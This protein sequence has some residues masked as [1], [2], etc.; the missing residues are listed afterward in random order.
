MA[1]T[2][3][4]NASPVMDFWPQRK[5]D[6]FIKYTLVL[7]LPGIA[8]FFFL[9]NGTVPCFG[10]RTRILLIA[11]W[12]FGCCWAVFTLRQAL[13]PCPMLCRGHGEHGTR[14]SRCTISWEEAWPGQLIWT[15]QRIFHNKECHVHYIN[16]GELA[17]KGPL[18]LGDG[19]SLS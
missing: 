2:L 6:T 1:E 9:V 5:F 15:G 14:A 17:M 10:C 18:L 12:C 7:V 4:A 3:T 16:Y 8:S 11:Q 13:L 19:L